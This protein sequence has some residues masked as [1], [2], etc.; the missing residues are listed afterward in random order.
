MI[1]EFK[2]LDFDNY[3]GDSINLTLDL[4]FDLVF[5]ISSRVEGIDTPELRGGPTSRKKLADWH[6]TKHVSLFQTQW[7]RAMRRSFQPLI[8]ESTADLLEIFDGNGMGNF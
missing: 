3:D 4:G 1:R 5:H 2:I 6:E 8:A 7:R